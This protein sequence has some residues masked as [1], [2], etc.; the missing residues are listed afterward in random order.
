M[1]HAVERIST[2]ACEFLLSGADS[3]KLGGADILGGYRLQPGNIAAAPVPEGFQC[4]SGG[5][6]A[7]PLKLYGLSPLQR[8]PDGSHHRS[9]RVD[10]L[11]LTVGHG[12]ALVSLRL[13]VYQPVGVCGLF[14]KHSDNGAGSDIKRE[15]HVPL[16]LLCAAGSRF[17]RGL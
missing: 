12:A 3:L 9:D 16:L 7:Y 10:V 17:L 5:G 6:N 11:D 8:S 15:Y 1:T 13:H 14:R 4:A 2:A